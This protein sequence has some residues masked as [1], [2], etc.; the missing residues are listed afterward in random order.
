MKDWIYKKTH[1]WARLCIDRFFFV[2]LL[3]MS[4]QSKIKDASYIRN[5][6]FG[7]EDSLVSTVGLVSGIAIA[8][9]D[10]A[11]IFLAGMVL[12]VVEALSMGV[13]SALAE[14]STEEY[15]YK[16]GASVKLPIIGGVIMFFSYFVAGFVPL[17]PYIFFSTATALPI[18]IVA[19]LFALF[20]L[21]AESAKCFHTNVIKS[22]ARMFFFGGLA[23]LAGMMVGKLLD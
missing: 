9:L 12:I 11:T 5:F 6:I 2:I 16:R 15:V 17:I 7:V 18:S 10:R 13:G 1:A 3:R 22:G 14:S 23:I 8:D 20:V 19:S 21:G 4:K